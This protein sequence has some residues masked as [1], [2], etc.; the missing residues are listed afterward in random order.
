MKSTSRTAKAAGTRKDV[1]AGNGSLEW[2]LHTRAVTAPIVGART[3]AQLEDN[4]GALGVVIPVVQFERLDA[5]SAFE[6]GFPHD[7]IARPLTRSVLFGDVRISDH[8]WG[9]V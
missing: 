9:E 5:A 4:L 6:L 1:A 8:T 3:L 2:A 7:F